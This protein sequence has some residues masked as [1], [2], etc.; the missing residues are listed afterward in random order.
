[1]SIFT[2]LAKRGVD[3]AVEVRSTLEEALKAMPDQTMSPE[4]IRNGLKNRGVQQIEIKQSGLGD[5]L[6]YTGPKLPDNIPYNPK[7]LLEDLK[8]YQYVEMKKS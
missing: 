3:W 8:A 5:Y 4:D 6:D 2:Q 7:A 1:M